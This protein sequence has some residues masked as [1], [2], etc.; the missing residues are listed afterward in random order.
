MD[1]KK[2]IASKLNVEG[3]SKED[4]EKI[5]AQLEEAGATIEIK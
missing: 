3:V 5:K 1:Y 4:A 2:Y